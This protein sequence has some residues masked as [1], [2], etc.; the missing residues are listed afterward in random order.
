[1][2]QVYTLS[3]AMYYEAIAAREAAA[4]AA[5][6]R[7]RSGGA[8]TDLGAVETALRDAGAALAGVM[9]ILQG[10]DVPPTAVQLNAIARARTAGAQ[11]MAKWKALVVSHR[12]A[13]RKQPNLPAG[14]PEQHRLPF[15]EPLL[16]HVG[17]EAGHRLGGVGRI[18]EHALGPRG[19]LDRLARCIRRDAVALADEAIVDFDRGAL[20]EVGEIHLEQIRDAADDGAHDA[21]SDA[22]ARPR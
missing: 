6:L 20:G 7:E 19:E 15:D 18:Q 12:V 5:A 8:T 3:K 22:A 4:A 2:Q 16:A 1:M 10:A 17:D 21:C 9:N 11:A 13:L 14:V